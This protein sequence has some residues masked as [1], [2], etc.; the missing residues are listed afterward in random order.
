MMPQAEAIIYD[1]SQN[2]NS[3]FWEIVNDGVMGGLSEGEIVLSENG[4]ALFEG[5]VTTE[6]NGGFSLV[7]HSFS[8][9]NVSKY[10]AVV[11][12]IK[13]DGKNY[14]FR[15]KERLDQEYSYV[16]N[17][18]SSGDWETIK[19]P[20][21]TCYAS[22]RGDAL[23][24]SNYNGLFMEGISFLVGNKKKEDFALEIERIWLE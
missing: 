16:H 4:N 13:G 15:I 7:K 22:L 18:K 24:L 19:I 1:S 3:D 11:M 14:Q 8:K 21:A 17:F 5:F 23:N 20:F 2:Q 10:K 12:R 9:K 6:N